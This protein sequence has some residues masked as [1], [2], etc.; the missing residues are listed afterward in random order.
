MSKRFVLLLFVAISCV[1]VGCKGVEPD[2]VKLSTHVLQ[3]K[4][5]EVHILTAVATQEVIW[6]SS[7]TLVAEVMKDFGRIDILV[8]NAGIYVANNFL[9]SDSSAWKRTFSRSMH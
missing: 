2:Q 9:K 6:Q 1:L 8:N 5:G 3:L 7:D 4:V